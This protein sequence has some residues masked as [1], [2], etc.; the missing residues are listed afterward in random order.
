MPRDSAL[1]TPTPM[2]EPIRV[3]E[4][5]AGPPGAEIPDDRSDQEREH[6]GEARTAADLQD[7]FDR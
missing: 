2:I 7:Q 3:C 4:L 1:A 5:E 6:H